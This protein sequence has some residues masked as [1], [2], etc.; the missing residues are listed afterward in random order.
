MKPVRSVWALWGILSGPLLAGL[1]FFLLY[2][3]IT[4]ACTTSRSGV[5]LPGFQIFA[6]AA[7][8]LTLAAILGV[9][10][11]RVRRMRSDRFA[12]GDAEV[13]RFI[14]IAGLLLATFSLIGTIWLAIATFSMATCSAG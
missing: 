7:T 11:S 6:L 4:L 13:D 9:I 3:G 14:D 8:A 12:A 10:V 2:A 5:P 1:Y